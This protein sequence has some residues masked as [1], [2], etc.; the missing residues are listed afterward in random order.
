[1]APYAGVGDEPGAPLE[2]RAAHQL[3]EHLTLFGSY[4]G[5]WDYKSKF[6]PE[7]EERF[8]IFQGGPLGLVKTAV[9]LIQATDPRIRR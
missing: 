2:E 6:E 4:K 7:W 3:A 9:A 1:M 5:V 8:L